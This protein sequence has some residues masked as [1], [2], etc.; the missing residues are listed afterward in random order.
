MKKWILALIPL[1]LFGQNF[2]Q[3]ADNAMYWKNKKPHAAYWQQD[4]FYKIDAI[5]DEQTDIISGTE[6]LTYFNN[7]PDTLHFVFFHL[8]QNAFVPGSYLDDLQKNN[9]IN[10]K[11]GKYESMQRGIVIESVK[12]ESEELEKILDNT[13]LKVYLKKPLL[14]N[15]SCVFNIQFKTFYDSGT[16]R[17]RMKKFNSYGAKHY[18]GCQWY[19]KLC[20]YDNHSGWNTDQHLNREFYGD[21]GSWDVTLNFASNYIVEA[22]GVLQNENEM[23]PDTLKQKIHIRNFKDKPWGEKPS[24][25]IPYKKGVRKIWKYHADN[26]HDFAFTA[27][28]NYRMADTFWNGVRC[29][30]IVQE[31]HASGWQTAAEYC[32]KIIK[33]FSE[34]FGMYE[35]PKMVVADAQDGMEYPMLTLDGG[36][37]PGYRGLLIHEVGHNWFYGMIGNNETYRAMMDEGFTQFLTSWGLEHIDGKHIVSDPIKNRY[38][39]FFTK[40]A[41]ARDAR[42]YYG[43]LADAITHSDEPLNTHSDNFHGAVGQGGGYRHVYMKTATMLYNLQYLLGDS[44]FS[45]AMKHYVAQWKMNHPYPEDFRNSIIQFTKADLNWFFDQW[46]ETTKNI[47]YKIAGV[48]KTEM[49][50]EYAI[51]LKRKGRM[52]MPIDLQ[53]ID[54][55]DSVHNFYIPNTWFEKEVSASTKLLPKWYGWDKLKPSYTAIVNIPNGIKNVIIDPSERL[56]D[57]NNYNNKLRGNVQILPDVHV[58]LF[59]SWQKYRIWMRHDVWYNAFDGVKIGL[60]ANGHYLA[61]IKHNFALNLWLNTHLGQGGFYTYTKEEKRA[62]AWISYKFDYSTSLDPVFK[63]T[64]INIHS[65]MLDGVLLNKVGLVRRFDNGLSIEGNVKLMTIPKTVWGNYLI[66]EQEWTSFFDQGNQINTSVNLILN[67]RFQKSIVDGFLKTTLRSATLFNSSNY[68]YLEVAYKQTVELW[69]FDLRT[70][71]YGRI[72]TGNNV[73]SESALFFAGANPEEMLD[74]KYMRAAAFFPERWGNHG[75]TT[76]HLHYGGGLNLRGYSGYVMSEKDNAGNTVWVYKG[77]SGAAINAELDFNRIV[78][79][80]KNKLRPYLDLNTYLFADA[81]SIVYKNSIGKNQFS[82][83]RVD[84][85]VGAALTIKKWGFLDNINP[86]TIRFDVPFYISHAPHDNNKNI[87]WRWVL[88]ISRAF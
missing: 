77:N 45:K 80:K 37:D 73:P 36:K 6:Q 74:N 67:Y 5:I 62:A 17:R 38:V 8:Y 10:V 43:Y 84:A 55:K 35:Y 11:Y 44:L 83:V 78:R 54:K 29:V 63:K 87:A 28:P 2:Y 27:N 21:F 88:G 86:L 42:V 15:N 20:V 1:S 9:G 70:R 4:V 66:N 82:Q 51:K 24:I 16:T 85:G 56:A 25:I 47:D 52:Q 60:H 26:V 33:C 48:K 19:P 65:R 49:T 23:L 34:D 13:I 59:P 57:V 18:N 68:H 79:F 69:R 58:N 53:V 76:S 72:G 81:G 32:A 46:M 50:N 3:S 14:P 75:A 39:K 31:P 41:N 64:R 61:G 22:T 7:S 30:T 12:D 40:P 71:V